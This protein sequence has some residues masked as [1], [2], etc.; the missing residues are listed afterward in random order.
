MKC[1]VDSQE[2]QHFWTCGHMIALIYVQGPSNPHIGLQQVE[3]CFD[4]FL[5]IS[6]IFIFLDVE[7]QISTGYP[8]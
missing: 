8:V 2:M 3:K 4:R 1:L 6:F 7:Q 5:N